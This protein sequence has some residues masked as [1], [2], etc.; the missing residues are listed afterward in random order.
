MTSNYALCMKERYGYEVIE[1]GF[2]FLTYRID[3]DICTAIEIFV[4]KENRGGEHWKL[5]W[6]E[7]HEI[8]RAAS[9]RSII[10]FVDTTKP[11]PTSRLLAYLRYGAKIKEV[12]AGLIILEW[13]V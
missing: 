5:L 10:G 1:H 11:D 7:L 6:Q 8:C 4:R 3:G 12:N 9:A 2:G 13:S